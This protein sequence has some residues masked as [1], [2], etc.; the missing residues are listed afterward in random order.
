MPAT[1]S[2]TF[3]ATSL[4]NTVSSDLRSNSPFEQLYA[5][6]WVQ[7]LF[8]YYNIQSLDLVMR[9]RVGSDLE[10]MKAL[11]SPV[12]RTKSIFSRAIGS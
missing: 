8:P 3:S 1:P 7:Q 9:P 5:I 2:W 4:T 11:S 6:E 10:L 12:Q